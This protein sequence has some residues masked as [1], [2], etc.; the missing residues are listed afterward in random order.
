MQTTVQQKIRR[1]IT[2]LKHGTVLF[3]SSFPQFDVEYVTKFIFLET[4]QKRF[5]KLPQRVTAE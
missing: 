4:L 2:R 5:R 1:M 3:A